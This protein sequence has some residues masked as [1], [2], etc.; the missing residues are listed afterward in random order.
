MKKYVIGTILL[1]IIYPLYSQVGVNTENPKGILHIKSKTLPEIN[2]DG[3]LVDNDGR[4]GISVSIDDVKRPSASVSLGATNKAFMPNNVALTDARGTGEGV[5]NPI[6]NP[7]EGMVIF[8]TNRAGV[9]PNNV[10]PGLYIFN[11]TQNRW[12]YCLIGDN[13]EV[14]MYSLRSELTLP[15]INYSLSNFIADSRPLSIVS[16]GSSDS[17]IEFIEVQSD[18]AYAM[19]LT[20]SGS[21]A[22]VNTFK[23]MVAYVAVVLLNDDNTVNKVLDIAEINPVAFP[24]GN[25]SG[26]VTY[27]L[28]LGFDAHRGE[29]ISVRIAAS[30]GVTKWTLQPKETTV[31]FFKI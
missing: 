15:E 13:L 6:K 18:A 31:V 26:G 9:V 7:V 29:K 21:I 10:V 1:M 25:R 30:I 2:N 14:N 27:P 16:I 8:N 17:G 20:L 5:N 24:Q 23:R 3:V 4:D 11:A 28:T 22:S 19:M 12:L